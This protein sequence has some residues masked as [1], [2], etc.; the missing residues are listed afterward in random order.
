MIYTMYAIIM[1]KERDRETRHREKERLEQSY[2][3]FHPHTKSVDTE[4][5]PHSHA[6]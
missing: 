3:N 2:V 6:C 1:N 4:I 5:A